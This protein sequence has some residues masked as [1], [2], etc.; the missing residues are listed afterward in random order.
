MINLNRFD[1]VSLRVLVAV[2]ETGSLTAGAERFGISLAAASR[3]VVDLEQDV[4]TRLLE[5]SKKGVT[6]T[7]AGQTL[8]R[9]SLRLVADLE[10]L[11]LA[12]GDYG[13]G[14]ASHVRLWVN[15]SA[16]NGLVPEALRS[17]LSANPLTKIDLEEALSDA[18]VRAVLNGSADL[19]IFSDNTPS[20]GLETT[21]CDVDELVLLLPRDHALARRPRVT[22]AE[23]IEHDFIGLERSASLLRLLG[24]AAESLGAS[25]KVRVQVRSFDAMCRMVALGIGIGVLPR[26]AA[27]PHVRSMQLAQVPLDEPWAERR[28]LLGCRSF[29]ALSR[30]ARALA[31]ALLGGPVDIALL[32][33]T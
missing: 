21:V 30:P 6:P 1:L 22:F 9:H 5:R 20:A 26:A 7:E 3:R 32:R 18:V 11:A 13:R 25:V 31:E 16:V 24:S 29:A 14:V 17:Y 2:I 28:L 19:G 23:A 12:M 10:G 4:G 15:T 33:Q 8:Y 27:M